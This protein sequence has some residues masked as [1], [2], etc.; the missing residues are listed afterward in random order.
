SRI[1]V[2]N[3]KL[4][5]PDSPFLY[6]FSVTLKGSGG[7]SIDEEHVVFG[8]REF[9]IE[10][11]DFLLNG[12]KI[13]LKGSN[14]AFHRFLSDG[15]RHLLPWNKSWIRK[16]LIEI[17]REHNFNFFRAHL[18]HMYNRWY[19]I[20]D[21]GGIMFQDEWQFWRA[22]GTKEQ[23]TKEFSDW[24]KD[25]WN[26]PSIVIWDALNESS[27]DVVQNE[28]IPEMKE[29]DPTRPWESHDFF[30]DHP[31]IYSLGPVLVDRNIPLLIL[32]EMPVPEFDTYSERLEGILERRHHRFRP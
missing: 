17:P 10:G 12:K 6:V 15:D 7:T 16:L 20:A 22:T 32:K 9:T 1:P 28:I 18:G 26:H 8:M 29:L 2:T 27:D 4:W 25:N 21:E 14:I 5:S 13:F 31:Y 3:A 23:I 11:P 19:D 30:E 24:L